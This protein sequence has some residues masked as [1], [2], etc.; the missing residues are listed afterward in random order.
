MNMSDGTPPSA[1]CGLPSRLTLHELQWRLDQSPEDG[2][3]REQVGQAHFALSQFSEAINQ[4]ETAAHHRT[5]SLQSHGQLAYCYLRNRRRDA[6]HDLLT[7]L[8]DERKNMDQETLQLVVR[9]AIRL[10]DRATL[11]VCGQEGR[12]RFPDNAIFWYAGGVSSPTYEF[13]ELCLSTASHLE[14]ENVNYRIKLC[15]L[16]LKLSDHEAALE[17]LA[18]DV[19]TVGCIANLMRVQELYSTLNN[20]EGYI[21]CISELRRFYG[22]F[23]AN[24]EN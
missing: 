6:A 18:F 3:L 19:A 2:R 4:F 22:E 1:A 9:C 14:P 21:E 5:L 24:D 23:E 13:A 16:Q 12:R 11:Q 8:C 20:M 7:R 17:T 15:Q 10:R